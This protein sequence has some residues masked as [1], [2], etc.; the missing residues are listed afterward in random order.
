MLFFNLDEQMSKRYKLVAGRVYRIRRYESN[1]A[2]SILKISELHSLDIHMTP[3]P[4]TS[5]MYFEL[6]PSPS[7]RKPCEKRG[8]GHWYEVSISSAQLD[9][10]LDQ[11]VK[12]QLGEEA[13]WTP[14]GL[15]RLGFAE[16]IYLPALAMLKKMDGVGQ[17]NNNGVDVRFGASTTK[18]QATEKATDE[19]WW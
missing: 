6:S 16:S 5:S 13:R 2:K 10:L 18:S 14:E 9:D 3:D 1:D 12:L 19:P 11:N 17:Y 8:L 7:D 4:K 15:S